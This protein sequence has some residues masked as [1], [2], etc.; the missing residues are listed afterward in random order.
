[1][2][3]IETNEILIVVITFCKNMQETTKP[4]KIWDCIVVGAGIEGSNT[5]RYSA[6]LG[7]KTLCLEQVLLRF[8]SYLIVVL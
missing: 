5:A 2:K 8:S 4:D 6:S 1:L 7:K 3:V